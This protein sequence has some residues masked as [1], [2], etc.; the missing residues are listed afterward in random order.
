MK[1]TFTHLLI[2]RW[3]G[4]V[5]VVIVHQ[6]AYLTPLHADNV[7][8]IFKWNRHLHR[9]WDKVL[10]EKVCACVNEEKCHKLK[11]DKN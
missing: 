5:D 9:H 6:A 2:R 4:N 11:V 10:K 7:A 8:M 1:S 3:D